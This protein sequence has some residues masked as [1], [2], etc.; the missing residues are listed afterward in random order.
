MSRIWKALWLASLVL[1]AGT[2][3][4]QDML[5]GPITLGLYFD[6]EQDLNETSILTAASVQAYL[7]V[8]DATAQQITGWEA[9]ITMSGDAS[10]TG[11]EVPVGTTLTS[12]GPEDWIASLAAPMPA[13][14]RTKLATFTIYSSAA[15]DVFIYLGGVPGGSGDGVYPAVQLD[16]GSW[17]RI[18]VP[19]GDPLA[20]VAGIDSTTPTDASSWGAVKS[21]FR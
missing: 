19:G 14:P 9:R 15:E 12:A 5:P 17:Y 3:G 10:I 1:A 20:P 7:I 2:A 4:A 16:D 8:R 21:L 13:N 18:D 11:H 6:S